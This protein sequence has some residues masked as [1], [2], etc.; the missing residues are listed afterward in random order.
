M[1][2]EGGPG[3]GKTVLAINLLTESTRKG[4]FA[5]YATR[6]SAPREVYKAKLTGSF[7]K[8]RIDKC[9]VLRETI[10]MLIKTLSTY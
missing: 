2:V 6:N 4:L 1:I 10:G 9:F 7:T 5:Q 3:T 8:S